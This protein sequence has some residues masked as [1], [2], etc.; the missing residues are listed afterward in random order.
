M[1][2]NFKQP[3]KLVLIIA[4]ILAMLFPFI[5]TVGIVTL[6]IIGLVYGVYIICKVQLKKKF[7]KNTPK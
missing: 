5:A 3:N 2:P 6:A 7:G 4:L 1:R